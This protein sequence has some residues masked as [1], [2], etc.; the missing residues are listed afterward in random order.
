MIL[1][2]LLFCKDK[3]TNSGFHCWC[4]SCRTKSRMEWFYKN[5][6]KHHK[7][8]RKWYIKNREMQLIKN[9]KYR[10]KN[11]DKVYESIKKWRKEN[12]EKV[13]QYE[14]NRKA[15][16]RGSE[17]KISYLDWKWMK[18]KYFYLCLSC[19]KREPE[20]KLTQDHVVPISKGGNNTI[21]DIQPL[22]KSCN[23]KKYTKI[24]DYRYLYMGKDEFGTYASL[25]H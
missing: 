22:C 8:W 3:Q 14:A 19:F 2:I 24:I 11:Y 6:D 13:M 5:K 12:K 17:G 21:D 9:K 15:L 25:C 23:S 7:S 10:E 20:I 18:E 4:K 1:D 16:S